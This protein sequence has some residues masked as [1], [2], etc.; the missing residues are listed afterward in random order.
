MHRILHQCLIFRLRYARTGE[1]K[2]R[3][4]SS[5]TASLSCGWKKS[6]T[7]AF[8]DLAKID[9]DGHEESVW[10]RWRVGRVAAFRVQETQCVS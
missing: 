7:E 1:E 5:S 9:V 10:G 8:V 3:S 4:V 6:L 2:Q